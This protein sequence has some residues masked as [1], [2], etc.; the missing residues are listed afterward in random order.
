MGQTEIRV[1]GFIFARGGSK[2]I[3]HKNIAMLNGK[4]LICHSIEQALNTRYLDEIFVSTDDPEIAEIAKKCGASIPFMRPAELAADD[5]AEWLSWQH[6]V[7]SMQ[8]DGVAFDLFVSVPATAPLRKPED[9]DASID[10][11]L[12]DTS[13][14]AVISVTQAHRHPAFNMVFVEKNGTARI[15]YPADKVISNRQETSKIFDITTVAYAAR[16]E[17]VLKSRSLFEGRIKT[18]EIPIER[19]LDID[20]PYDLKLAELILNDQSK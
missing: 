11:L 1:C 16:P 10:R 4:P 12:D 20:T 3:P 13:A 7:K 19:A 6:A 9:I 8:A 17:F 18:I 15:A 14:D 5:S 2:G